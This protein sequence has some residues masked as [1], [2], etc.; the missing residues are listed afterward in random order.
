MK[1]ELELA[2]IIRSLG[3]GLVNI[4][5]VSTVAD[6]SRSLS[7]RLS[8]NDTRDDSRPLAGRGTLLTQSLR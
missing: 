4:V 7:A 8:T 2:Q 3:N 1:L 5:S 6:G